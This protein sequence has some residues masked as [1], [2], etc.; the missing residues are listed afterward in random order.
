MK[1]E[2]ICSSRSSQLQTALGV[3]FTIG[4]RA[5]RNSKDYYPIAKDKY[6]SDSDRLSPADGIRTASRE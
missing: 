4:R 2:K 5:N 3:A 1:L 6:L